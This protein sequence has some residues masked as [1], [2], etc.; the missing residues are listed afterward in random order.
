M[1]FCL[2]ESKPLHIAVSSWCANKAKSRNQGG[3]FVRQQQPPEL[4]STRQALRKACTSVGI[5]QSGTEISCSAGNAAACIHGPFM[6]ILSCPKV[7]ATPATQHQAGPVEGVQ[8]CRYP[9]VGYR[10][11]L[12][13]RQRCGPY[14]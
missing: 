11:H 9:S 5:P 10:G 14:L 12:Q 4:A 8:K 1:G 3:E 7:A 13:G 6:R 2:G